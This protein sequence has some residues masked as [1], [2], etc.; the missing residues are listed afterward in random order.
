[1]PSWLR[2]LWAWLSLSES[3]EHG[4]SVEEA[5]ACRSLLSFPSRKF[6]TSWPR[7][8][9]A[10]SKEPSWYQPFGRLKDADPHF[11][12]VKGPVWNCSSLCCWGWEIWVPRPRRGSELLQQCEDLSYFQNTAH[13]FVH[14]YAYMHI[15]VCPFVSKPIHFH[16]SDTSGRQTK[17]PHGTSPSLSVSYLQQ[18]AGNL[19]H[20]PST[21]SGATEWNNLQI[22]KDSPLFWACFELWGSA[23]N[24]THSTSMK[25]KDCVGERATCVLGQSNKAF[26]K[27][28]APWHHLGF[29]LTLRTQKGKEQ[30]GGRNL[31]WSD[32]L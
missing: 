10:Q 11:C 22:C 21:N 31:A 9:T 1:M 23:P 28:M 8:N 29:C 4:F 30:R 5:E 32:S 16:F 27:Y 25:C 17:D 7:N 6:P 20:G 24:L 13:A 15:F 12:F 19:A 2:V 18:G 3:V 14:L 26:A